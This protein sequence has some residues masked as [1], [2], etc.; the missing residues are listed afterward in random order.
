MF[1]SKNAYTWAKLFKGRKNVFDEDRLGRPKGVRTPTMIKSVDETI[2]WGRMKVEDIAHILNIS[3]GIA[4]EIMHNNQ[5]K[6]KDVKNKRRGLQSV[7]V[8]LHQDNARPHTA[9]KTV[10]TISQFC[11]EVLLHP[12]PPLYSSTDLAFFDFQLF[13][14]LKEFSRGTKFTSDEEIK[15]L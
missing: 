6:K 3:V 10:E 14:P 9:A 13:G 15:T 12:P 8:I 2:Q 1:Q 7:G 4:H 5:D 11:W